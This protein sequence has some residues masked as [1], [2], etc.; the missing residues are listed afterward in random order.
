VLKGDAK[1]AAVKREESIAK[2]AVWSA[3]K[4]GENVIISFSSIEIPHSSKRINSTSTLC[5]PLRD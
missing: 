1:L 4:Q 3:G 5:V 2:S